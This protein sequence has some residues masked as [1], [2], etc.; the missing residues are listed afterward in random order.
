MTSYYFCVF[1]AKK[2]VYKYI[3]SRLSIIINHNMETFADN[4]KRDLFPGLF[5]KSHTKKMI[6]STSLHQEIQDLIR[7]DLDTF[8]RLDHV[9][10]SKNHWDLD[11]IYPS[12]NLWE[13]IYNNAGR[14]AEMSE[15]L[16][17]EFTVCERRTGD[18]DAYLKEK[19]KNIANTY[20]RGE[21]EHKCVFKK[22]QGG[23]Y[24]C[25]CGNGMMQ[26]GADSETNVT[27]SDS[28]SSSS[29]SSPSSDDDTKMVLS[30]STIE[31]DDL[32]KMRNGLYS[33]NTD[34]ANSR[35]TMDVDDYESDDVYA[36][37]DNIENGQDEKLFSSEEDE[38]L[39]MNSATERYTKR[40]IKKNGKYY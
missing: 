23:S 32:E 37:I 35:V 19:N 26:G 4:N 36:V 10:P 9:Y 5:G 17:L 39:A 27:S 6:K 20:H 14:S 22:M 16:S 2:Y 13:R 34:N 28:S 12:S 7:N 15:P 24:Q 30:N 38:I 25:P 29:V 33:G 3:F 11:H 8:R 21:P 40:P 1:P 31:T 18:L